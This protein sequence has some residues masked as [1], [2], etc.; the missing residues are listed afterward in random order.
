MTMR[1]WMVAVAAVG[2]LIGGI[3]NFK[4]RRDYFLARAQ[5]HAAMETL[6]RGWVPHVIA[7]LEKRAEG[8]ERSRLESL[9][10][11]LPREIAYHAAMARKYRRA[12]RYPWLP[13]GPD[14]SEPW[15]PE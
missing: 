13:V 5:N 6:D 4:Q 11:S 9:R 3:I 1:R 8:Q 10:A 15:K 14:P 12:V 2:L 7:F